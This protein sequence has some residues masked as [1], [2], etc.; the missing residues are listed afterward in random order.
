[1]VK[2]TT[3][4]FEILN[5]IGNNE[6]KNSAVFLAKDNQL[7]ATL[8]VKQ[9]TKESLE[10]QG[11]SLD[12]YY[13]ES[14][15]LYASKSSYVVEIQYA[16][17][18][19]DNIYLTMPYLK[20][21]SLSKKMD[22][23]YLTIREIV[24]YSNDILNGLAVIHSKG[25]IHL[26]IKPTNILI[27]DSGKCKITDFGLSRFVD[28]NGFANQDYSYNWHREPE[29]FTASKRSVL[30]DIYQ[31]GVT[32]YRMCNG[33]NILN[34][35]A[36]YL[37]INSLEKLYKCITDG[38]FPDRKY[39]LPHIPSK[40]R[41]IIGK[42]LNINPVDRYENVIEILNDLNSI[43]SCLDWRYCPESEYLYQKICDDKKIL[44]EVK[45][46]KRSVDI[47]CIRTDSEGNNPRRMLKYCKQN[48]QDES[49][50]KKHIEYIIQDNN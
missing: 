8:V 13:N 2:N 31:F 17:E 41:R 16:C 40:L 26:D 4:T 44:I 25:L 15:A 30:S 47:I 45:E 23:E 20:C 43:N 1:M 22:E 36:R 42:C 10:R 46:H 19:K 39:Y 6:G 27:D 37:N 21:G 3:L 34:E 24:K 32:L 14:K 33:N 5:P 7:G 38:E 35:Q 29:S 48:L 12:D 50:I 49:S 28:E 18:D 11:I 9:I